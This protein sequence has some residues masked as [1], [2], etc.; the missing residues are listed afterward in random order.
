MSVESAK[1]KESKAEYIIPF[2][3]SLILVA[4]VIFSLYLLMPYETEVDYLKEKISN[5]QNVSDDYIQGWN[6]CI[7]ELVK[8]RNTATNITNLT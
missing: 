4:S 2:F 6:D 8:L 5:K 7:S 1:E 3:I